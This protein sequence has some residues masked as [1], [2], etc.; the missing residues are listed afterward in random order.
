MF[1]NIAGDKSSRNNVHMEFLSELVVNSTLESVGY[2]FEYTHP[3]SEI[4]E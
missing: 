4:L 3:L 1:V 2:P